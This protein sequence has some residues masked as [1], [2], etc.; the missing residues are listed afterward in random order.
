MK[1]NYNLRAKVILTLVKVQ[2]GKSLANILNS[3]LNKLDHKDKGL[4][5]EL[6]LGTLRQWYSLKAIALPLLV[7]PINNSIVET[8]LYVGL[9]QTLCTNVASHAAI[10]E[11]VTAVKQ[12]GYEPL[13][14]VINAIL[15]K[16]TN[17]KEKFKE[18]LYNHHGLPSWLAKRLKKDWSESYVQLCIALKQTA[19]LTLRINQRKIDRNSYFKKL[20]DLGI[21]A[22]ICEFSKQAIRIKQSVSISELPFFEEGYF[23]VQDEHAQLCGELSLE[24]DSQ[25]VVDACAAPGG[26][27]GHL[28]EKYDIK[29]LWALDKDEARLAKVQENLERLN[30]LGNNVSIQATDGITWTSD[31]LVDCIIL[32]APC[33]ATGVIRRHPDIKLLRKPEDIQNIVTLQSQILT[34]MWKNLKVGG[35]LVY[36]TCSLLKVENEKQIQNFLNLNSDAEEL[37]ISDDWGIKQMHGRQLLPLDSKSGDGFYYC[38]L[39]KK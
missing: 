29:K 5:H 36:V 16:S 2:E 37:H 13:S 12:L 10:S 30:L 31:A 23:S 8:S 25:N 33:S 27:T 35:K 3:E 18:L 9:Y 1:N 14:G 22:E 21:L 39:E 11:T 38:I 26:K 4:F 19:P 6:V 32:D 34:N 28:L 24:L 15:R 20:I 17:E 7:K